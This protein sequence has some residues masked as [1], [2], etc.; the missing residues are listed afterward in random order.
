M[1]EY[2]LD[3]FLVRAVTN[4]CLVRVSSVFRPHASA[5]FRRCAI[6]FFNKGLG[7]KF[8]VDFFIL[9]PGGEFPGR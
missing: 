7:R 9:L 5:D 2:F 3:F 8:L 1:S 6:K 4:D